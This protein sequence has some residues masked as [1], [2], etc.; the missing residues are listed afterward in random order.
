MGS[1]GRR[2]SRERGRE[3]RPWGGGT[4]EAGDGESAGAGTTL[5][6]PL[7]RGVRGRCL[8]RCPGVSDGAPVSLTLPRRCPGV[9]GAAPVSL[10]LP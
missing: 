8:R 5:P 10:A 6:G 7:L 9:P 1:R 4:R 2:E 3:E